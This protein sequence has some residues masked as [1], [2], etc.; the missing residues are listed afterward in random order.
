[1]LC[2]YHSCGLYCCLEDLV[3][4]KQ[5]VSLGLSGIKA[6]LVCGWLALQM[7]NLN[8]QKSKDM[9]ENQHCVEDERLGGLPIVSCQVGTT[10]PV[11]AVRVPLL[12]HGAFLEIL[13]PAQ[14]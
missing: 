7:Q 13:P 4:E 2:P 14:W 3:G 6:V 8:L 12:L 10:V 1:M 11:S 5:F 9:G